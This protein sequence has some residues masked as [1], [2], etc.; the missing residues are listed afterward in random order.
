M[1]RHYF[2]RDGDFYKWLKVTKEV[3]V[4]INYYHN[5]PR[6]II[7]KEEYIESEY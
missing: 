2:F 4:K 3:K 7:S 5:N 1:G 6:G